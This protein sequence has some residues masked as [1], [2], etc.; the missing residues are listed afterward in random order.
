MQNKVRVFNL[1][2]LV[3]VALS[4]IWLLL[5]AT[6]WEESVGAVIGGF[7]WGAPLFLT[8][9]ALVANADPRL[10]VKA[11]RGNAAVA[12]L[13]IFIWLVGAALS[14]PEGTWLGWAL[15]LALGA[16]LIAPFLLNIFVLRGETARS[17]EIDSNS[18]RSDR[19]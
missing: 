1:V 12:G 9:R 17:R 2:L 16:I 18:A 15:V 13:L 8:A 3:P 7:L 4:T 6:S 11:L 14:K 5:R 19:D 10:R